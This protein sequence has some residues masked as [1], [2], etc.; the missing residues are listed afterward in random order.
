ML[1]PPGLVLSSRAVV[2]A[3]CRF[4]DGTILKGATGLRVV[5]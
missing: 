1:M 3:R 4:G 5:R 2:A